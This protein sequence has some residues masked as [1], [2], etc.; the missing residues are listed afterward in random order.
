[1][2][3]FIN[4]RAGGYSQGAYSSFNISPYSSDNPTHVLQNKELLL[5]NLPQRPEHIILPHQTHGDT[6]KIID[7]EFLTWDANKQQNYLENTDALITAEKGVCIGVSTADCV[8]VLLYDQKLQL[9]AAIHAGW[10][11]TVKQIVRKTIEC[12]KE[13]YGSSPTDLLAGIG[14]SIGPEAFEVGEEVA[15][16]FRKFHTSKKPIIHINPDTKK[17][18]INLWMANQNQ[19][20]DCGVPKEQIEIANV[21]THSNDDMLFSARRLGISSGRIVSGIYLH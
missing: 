6:T 10:R 18:H 2:S 16:E 21:C 15:D 11:G 8:P 20:M 5:N 17:S 7:A 1:M 9:V 4:T 13:V 14:P 19:L 3:H 12:M